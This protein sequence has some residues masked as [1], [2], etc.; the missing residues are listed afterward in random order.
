MN[1]KICNECGIP[2]IELAQ[3]LARH[4]CAGAHGWSGKEERP[5]C[6][7]E[8]KGP[9]IHPGCR[10]EIYYTSNPHEDGFMYCPY[11][12]GEIEVALPHED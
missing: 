11:C 7:W 8:A 9:V 1:G 10:K 12:G 5:F 6:T 3:G 4:A 2:W